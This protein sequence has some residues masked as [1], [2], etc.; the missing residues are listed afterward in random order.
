MKETKDPDS[1][2]KV[3]KNRISRIRQNISDI[4]ENSVEKKV[5]TVVGWLLIVLICL[6]IAAVIVSTIG[7]IYKTHD[8]I[9][10]GFEF[11]SI[12]IFTIEY[13]LRIWTA[14]CNKSRNAKNA[15]LGYISSFYG[16]VDLLAFLPFYLPL[17][18]GVDFRIFRLFR[19]LRVLKLIRYNNPLQLITRVFKKEKGKLLT[20]IFIMFILI[21]LASSLMYFFE[22][23]AQPNMFPNIP[24][25]LWWAV[26][27]LTTV[28]YGDV[29]PIT[30]LGKI[31][32]GIISI[33]GIGLVAMPSGIIAMG[34][35]QEVRSSPADPETIYSVLTTLDRY[36]RYIKTALSA[37]CK[38]LNKRGTL[39][40]IYHLKDKGVSRNKDRYGI[41][42]SNNVERD[43]LFC[44]LRPPLW[45]EK[46]G[47]EYVYSL[48]IPNVD[49]LF[50][51][52]IDTEKYPYFF[53]HTDGLYIQIDRDIFEGEHPERELCK[54]IVDIVKN[55][56][57]KSVK[58][59]K[60]T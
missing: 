55:V 11:I 30:V 17:A 51:E 38:E 18:F 5:P 40:F 56:Y 13:A 43:D 60:S 57:E 14:P 41:Y 31:L 19:L 2:R 20:T 48:C 52:K 27:T 29:Y 44:G 36:M 24:A 35:I 9:F 3:G 46:E 8:K 10:F 21:L 26:A 23:K 34:L 42:L 7:D 37:A 32:G 53:S 54:R 59:R 49:S 39:Y 16:I 28:G 4:L 33:L 25:T 22:N 47:K 45:N 58:Q 1:N 50:K 15:Y 12:F 6:N